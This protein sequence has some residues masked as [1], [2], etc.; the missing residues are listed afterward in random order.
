MPTA[1]DI[2]QAAMEQLQVYPAGERISGADSDRAVWVLNTMLDAWNNDHLVCYTVATRSCPLVPGRRMYT[3]GPGT[4][5]GTAHVP[6]DFSGTT[7]PVSLIDGYGTAYLIDGNGTKYGVSIVPLEVWHSVTDVNK[8]NSTLPDVLYYRP[9]YP[10]AVVSLYPTP[11]SST[12]TLYLE[13]YSALANV[14][15]D[16]EVALPA[17]YTDAI[18]TNLAVRL[19]D[20]Y[21]VKALSPTLERAARQSLAALKRTN[22]RDLQSRYDSSLVSRAGGRYNIYRDNTR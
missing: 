6:A 21:H 8:V 4:G 13:T 12:V 17:G 5:T 1:R 3:I 11:T 2:I 7:R 15:L 14:A 20:Y 10:N 18:Q 9:D 22:T 16:D 19:H